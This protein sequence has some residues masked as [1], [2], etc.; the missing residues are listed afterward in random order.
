MNKL[1]MHFTAKNG[2]GKDLAQRLP[3]L[4]KT[5]CERLRG[6]DLQ[7]V[8]LIAHAEDPMRMTG[9]MQ[10][11][12]AFDASIEIKM[13]ARDGSAQFENIVLGLGSRFENEIH[14]DLSALQIGTHK[15]IVDCD[16][17]PV[18]F[19]YCMRRRHDFSHAD[20]LRRYL[21][22]HAEFGIKTQGI[23]GYSQFHIDLPP[24]ER[25]CKSAGFGVSG[26]DSVSSLHIASAADFFA[27]GRENAKLG[28]GED[29]DQFVDRPSSVMWISDEVFR[30]G[31]P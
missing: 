19:Q 27:A 22:I 2:K 14:N 5:C 30:I 15:S 28:A 12:R 11:S 24:T 25:A 16:P 29:E 7:A 21:E 4:A 3:G 31:E 26:V 18:R 9:A 23:L 17:T 6:D 1:L 13:A 20:Y 10:P 8:V